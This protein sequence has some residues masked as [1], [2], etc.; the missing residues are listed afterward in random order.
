MSSESLGQEKARRRNGV[1][2]AESGGT[3]KLLLAQGGLH[4]FREER[5]TLF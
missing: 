1:D 3:E 5:Q 2:M 4:T